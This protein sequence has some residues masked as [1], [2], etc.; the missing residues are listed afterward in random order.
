MYKHPIMSWT[1][2]CVLFFD[3]EAILWL[4]EGHGD[5]QFDIYR[6]M[7]KETK[8]VSCQISNIVS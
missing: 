4:F 7:R 3:L 5:S 6:K 2:E 8:F 1:D